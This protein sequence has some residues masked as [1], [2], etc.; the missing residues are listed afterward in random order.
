MA[1]ETPGRAGPET[2]RAAARTRG[3]RPC[4]PAGRR[5][6]SRRCRERCRAR[7]AGRRP[8]SRRRTCRSAAAA[9]GCRPRSSVIRPLAFAFWTLAW[10]RTSISR[11]KS[12][13]DDRRLALRPR[14]RRPGPGRPCPCSSR[15]RDARLR[16]RDPRRE[17]PPGSIDVQAEQMVEEVVPPRDRR[18]HPPHPLVGLVERGFPAARQDLSAR[19]HRD[20]PFD[21]IGN[22][23]PDTGGLIERVQPKT[24]IGPTN[25]CGAAQSPR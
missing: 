8:R 22:A 24:V 9:A 23:H 3:S 6:S 15:A 1:E 14:G 4:R 10:P 19:L 11:Q 20:R 18:E 5:G 13:R 21:L 12:V 17:G 16:S 7:C 25:S 2:A